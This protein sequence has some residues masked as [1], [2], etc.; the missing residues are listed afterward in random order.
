VTAGLLAVGLGPAA[1]QETPVRIPAGE[2]KALDVKEVCPV[3]GRLHRTHL[4]AARY[5]GRI[6]YTCDAAALERFIRNPRAF[7]PES[8][9]QAALFRSPSPAVASFGVWLLVLGLYVVLGLVSG[10]FAAY[11]AVQKG[12][13][14]VRWFAAGLGLNVIGVALAFARPAREVAF[15][16]R[17]LTKIPT[18]HDP[19]PCPACG[20]PNHPSASRCGRCGA[21]LE[22]VVESEVARAMQGGG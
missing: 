6:F 13:G 16:R 21:E 9:P 8:T 22:P 20:K 1:G 5:R 12:L 18:T 10:A 2:L 4:Y 14:G 19:R 15:T 17:G 7:V 3:S 11:V